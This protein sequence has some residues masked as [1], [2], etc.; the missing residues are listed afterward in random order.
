MQH[1]LRIS[2]HKDQQKYWT[3]KIKILLFQVYCPFMHTA[4]SLFKLKTILNLHDRSYLPIL[5]QNAQPELGAKKPP[6]EL[7]I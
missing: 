7:I 6:T 2:T 4:K 1:N 5:M 3:E